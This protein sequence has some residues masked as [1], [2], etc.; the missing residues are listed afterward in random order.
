MGAAA[1]PAAITGGAGLLGGLLNNQSQQKTANAANAGAQSQIARQNLLFDT[2][3]NLAKNSAGSLSPDT[4]IAN[5]GKDA[6][7]WNGQQMLGTAAALKTSGYQPGDSEVG[8][9]LARTNA[10]NQ[11][12]FVNAANQIRV[13]ASLQQ[14]AL[15]GAAQPGSLNAGIAYNQGQQQSAYGRMTSPGAL[16]ASATPFMDPNLYKRTK[17]FNLQGTTGGDLGG[18]YEAY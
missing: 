9:Q 15:Y 12:A 7:F 1:I 8:T 11:R 3:M 14:E 4:Q 16:F 10:I 2:I 17:G 5:L 6:S 18:G 13:N